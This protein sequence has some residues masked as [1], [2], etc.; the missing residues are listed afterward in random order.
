SSVTCRP[1][2]Y[3]AARNTVVVVTRIGAVYGWPVVGDGTRPSVVKKSCP[4]PAA[5]RS[6]TSTGELRKPR[7][8]LT[9]ILAGF[10]FAGLSLAAAG[11][12]VGMA[13]RG[14]ATVGR[15]RMRA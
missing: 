11:R 7:V 2:S 13:G 5:V 15:G 4:L 3:P 12:S 10:F 8:W 1:A 14:V 6:V 9:L